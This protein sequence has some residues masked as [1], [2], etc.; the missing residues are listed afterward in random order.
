MMH[1][2]CSSYV[3]NIPSQVYGIFGALLLIARYFGIRAQSLKVWGGGQEH[4]LAPCIY[5]L[6]SDPQIPCPTLFNLDLSEHPN[7]RELLSRALTLL[8]FRLSEVIAALD[9][10]I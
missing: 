6:R 2:S 7:T 1:F 9:V 3:C 10:F 8:A 4:S 5:Q